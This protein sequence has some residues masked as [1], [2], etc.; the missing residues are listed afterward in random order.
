MTT[1]SAAGSPT[2]AGLIRDLSAGLV[3]FLVALPLC[4]GIAQASGT[5]EVPVPLIAGLVSGIVGGLVVGSLSGSHTS[6]SGPAA[7]LVA[8]VAAQLT[9]L[10]SFEAFLAAV[11]IAGFLQIG[12][13]LL[14]AGVMSAYV[15]S[16]VIHGLLAAIG[17]ILILKQIPHAL[18]HDSDP[19]GEMSFFQP[20]NR[21]TFT[22]L[23]EIANDLHFGAA[24]I[25]VG[26]VLLLLNWN[27]LPL[28]K[29][30]K[31]PPA[32]VI[33]ALG[34][35]FE[36]LFRISGT[37][38]AIG[39]THLVSIPQAASL[40]QTLTLFTFPDF[41]VLG[42]STVWLAG[43][44]I[45]I[46]ASLETL[47]NL[48][49]VDQLDHR[50]RHSPPDRELLA[51]GAGNIVSGLCGGL[52][53]TSVI[54]R[55]SVNVASGADSRKSA[56][57]HGGFLLV[58]VVFMAGVMN[59]IPLASLAAILLTTGI[60]LCSPALFVRMYKAGPYQFLPFVVTVLAIV[61][62]DLLIGIL[63]G[64]VVALGFVLHSNS[65]RPLRQTVERHPGGQVTRLELAEQV[66]FVNRAVLDRVLR[67]LEDGSS[68]L[69][70][71]RNTVYIDP[72]VQALILEFRDNIAPAHNIQ[73]S[74][75]G[76]RDKYG[77]QDE[78]H[79]LEHTTQEIQ[80][81]LKPVEVLQRLMQGNE[82]F[83]S[84]HQL[85][86]DYSRQVA[87]TATGQHPLAVVLSCID[88][89]TPAELVFD[90]GLGDI[91]SVRV[92]GN[93]TS[94]KVLG[95]MEY[96]CAVAGAKLLLVM[97][98]TRCGA[99]TAAV[100]VALRG[101]DP[102]QETGCS[103]L[104][105]ILDDIQCGL[106]P[107]QLSKAKALH[108]EELAEFVDGVARQNVAAVVQRIRERSPVLNRMI[109]EHTIGIAGALYDVRSGRMEF[110]A[111]TIDGMAA[112]DVIAVVDA[113]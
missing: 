81:G 45:A 86:R 57:I 10:G 60:K 109:E 110:L 66:S 96:G 44:T 88:S 3:V 105:P 67:G 55:S 101:V 21:N 18:G 94:P 34:L 49:A 7:G 23:L 37:A 69:I 71:A 82:R 111:E 35:V 33:V 1:P 46:V 26:S 22:E 93:V 99:V 52:P 106:T 104:G 6:V 31:A 102:E 100:D 16:S 68:V 59:H 78:I 9:A 92:A 64:L 75:T 74:L 30:I 107:E 29:F 53:I 58:A 103:N 108:G 15:P 56:I 95:S 39:D 70:D 91:F 2:S 73:V 20:D 112:N 42:S 63:I 87:C 89:R 40:S 24:L 25:G 48:E 65:R 90:L 14:R 113:A 84:G 97:G 27:R 80:T 5:P 47:L 13:G 76:F 54:V 50:K 32:F 38:L 79:Y 83:R 8:V 19:D 62:S 36:W 98:H 43:A 72:D 11:V 4:L 51:Q 28:V 17:A 77:L 85:R 41:S 12:L 61:F